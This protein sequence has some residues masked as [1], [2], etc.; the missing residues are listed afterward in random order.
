MTLR[1]N[2]NL[3]RDAH[4]VI[5]GQQAYPVT[6]LKYFAGR[7]L[8]DDANVTVVE[9]HGDF[10]AV[11]DRD[12]GFQRIVCHGTRDAA[13]ETRWRGVAVTTGHSHAVGRAVIGADLDRAHTF[14][15]AHAYHLFGQSRR[16]GQHLKR[17][18][19]ISAAL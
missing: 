13:D 9:V 7:L 17:A 14:D 5:A 11:L 6:G 4:A 18:V 16:A 2:F 1:A 19:E 12:S 15:C 10:K 8:G 3:M